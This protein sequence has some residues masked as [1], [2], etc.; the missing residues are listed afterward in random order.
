MYHPMSSMVLNWDVIVGIA[1]ETIILSWLHVNDFLFSSECNLAGRQE[2]DIPYSCKTSPSPRQ[3]Q[4]RL[5]PSLADTVVFS[6]YYKHSL[7][8]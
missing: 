8:Q 7:S 2:V 6:N 5:H 3:A 4:S 1:V